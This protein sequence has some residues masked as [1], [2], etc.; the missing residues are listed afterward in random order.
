VEDGSLQSDI[1]DRLESL[2]PK[3]KEESIKAED[4]IDPRWNKLKNLLKDK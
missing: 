3:A 4:E 1:L 2:A